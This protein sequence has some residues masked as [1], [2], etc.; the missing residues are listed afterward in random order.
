MRPD[1]V[2]LDFSR[3]ELNNLCGLSVSDVFRP[4]KWKRVIS[5][6]TFQFI[7][8]FV[9]WILL[10]LAIVLTV[11]PTYLL[12]IIALTMI[13]LFNLSFTIWRI[14]FSHQNKGLLK[15]LDGV[16]RYNSLIKSIHIN[17]QL[18]EAGNPQVKLE[19]RDRVIDALRL[20]REDIVRALQT[21][22]ILRKNHKFITQNNALFINNLTNLSA[23]QLSDRATEHGRIL[24]E[25]LQIAITTQSEVR[26]LQSNE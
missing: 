4:W 9:A 20:T 1:L 24:N 17:D 2:G 25:A 5:T 7:A 12:A 6:L 11:S 21:E 23:L 3:R 18:E 16:D 15:L 26:K 13:L 19:N 14:I 10:Y 8:N 22:K